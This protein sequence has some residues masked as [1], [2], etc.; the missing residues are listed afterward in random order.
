MP[1]REDKQACWVQLFNSKEQITL[2]ETWNLCAGFK[3]LSHRDIIQE[4]DEAFFDRI[5]EVV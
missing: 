4:F 3:Q 5:E 2:L 1:T